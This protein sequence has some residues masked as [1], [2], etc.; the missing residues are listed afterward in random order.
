MALSDRE[1]VQGWAAVP[2]GPSA[3]SGP[4]AAGA[5]LVVRC[6]GGF[7]LEIPGRRLDWASVRPRVRALLRFLAAHGGRPV[8]REIILAALWPELPL[9]SGVRNLHVGVS[10]LR[11][12]LE[13]GLRR[14]ESRFVRRDGESYLLALPPSAYCDV[15]SFEEAV[16]TWRRAVCT[17]DRAVAVAALRDALDQYGGD[18]LPEDGPAEWVVPERDRYRTLAAESAA[19][20]AALE[21]EAGRLTAAVTA[22]RRGLE[23]DGFRDDAWRVLAEAQQRSGDTAAYAR[24]RRA[25]AR[26]LRT[27][28]VDEPARVA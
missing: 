16:A 18:L 6:F 5:P 2:P 11:A 4:A 23:L 3:G 19:T 20:L 17:G 8:H 27:L 15:R 9:R 1:P 14:G 24:T 10:M 25:Y 26:M 21:L 7:H 13:P 28:G 22:A 12:F